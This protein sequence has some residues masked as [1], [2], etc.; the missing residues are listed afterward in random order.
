[1]AFY[2]LE[3]YQN[4]TVSYS[5]TNDLIDVVH[6]DLNVDLREHKKLIRLSGRIETQALASKLRAISFR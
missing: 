2:G 5:D 3:D 1:M 6:Y 4:G